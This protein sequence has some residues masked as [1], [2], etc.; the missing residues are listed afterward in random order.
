MHSANPANFFHHPKKVEGWRW[1]YHNKLTGA[2]YVGLL[3]GLLGVAGMIDLIVSQWII[4]E[5]FPAFWD[6][7]RYLQTTTFL[8]KQKRTRD[9][10]QQIS[11]ELSHV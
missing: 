6:F 2:F 8:L 9:T 10:D 4:P 11:A 7:G 5:K 3:D 1:V